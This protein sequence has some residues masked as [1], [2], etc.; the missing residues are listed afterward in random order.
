MPKVSELNDIMGLKKGKKRWR[1]KSYVIVILLLSH[2]SA[3]CWSLSMH[4]TVSFWLVTIAVYV[5]VMSER[6]L[7]WVGSSSLLAVSVALLH[8]RLSRQEGGRRDENVIRAPYVVWGRAFYLG[9]NQL[10]VHWA[11]MIGDTRRWSGIFWL[12]PWIPCV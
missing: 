10:N 2:M 12:F 8:I 1:W 5:W 11:C 3:V 4:A 9:L 7:S 6:L